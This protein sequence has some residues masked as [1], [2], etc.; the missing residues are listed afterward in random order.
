MNQ[1]AQHVQSTDDADHEKE[2]QIA[3]TDPSK[4]FCVGG[5]AI[6]CRMLL[7]LSPVA[8]H[9]TFTSILITVP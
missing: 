1:D 9:S 2:E 6:V 8:P 7:P 5:P 3:P 4:L